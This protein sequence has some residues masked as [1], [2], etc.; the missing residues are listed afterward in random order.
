LPDRVHEQDVGAGGRFVARDAGYGEAAAL[1]FGRCGVEAIGV[2]RCKDQDQ[3]RVR[4]ASFVEGVEHHRILAFAGG[5]RG[6]QRPV[7][8]RP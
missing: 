4:A 5:S 7:A 6:D 2:A 3:P 1:R 8:S